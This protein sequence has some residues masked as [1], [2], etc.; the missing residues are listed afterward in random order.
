MLR[1]QAGCGQ[2]GQKEVEVGGAGIPCVWEGQGEEFGFYPG[3]EE[4]CQSS[5]GQVWLCLPERLL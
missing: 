4:A 5:T 3:Y 1:R 2:K